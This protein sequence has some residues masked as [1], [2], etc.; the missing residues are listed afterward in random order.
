MKCDWI[1]RD[2]LWL[3]F[4]MTEDNKVTGIEYLWKDLEKE[5]VASWTSSHAVS[6]GLSGDRM[7][8]KLKYRYEVWLN[9]LRLALTAIH[10][11]SCISWSNVCVLLCKLLWIV[12]C[13]FLYC[14]ILCTYVMWMTMMMMMMIKQ[15]V[16]EV[17]VNSTKNEQGYKAS[18]Q[19]WT[20]IL[21]WRVTWR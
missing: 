3:Q 9:F 7:D 4:M 12:S 21:Y 18:M 14:V 15:D 2:W 20:V 6:T 19:C 5:N 1:L 17:A 13:A 10:S 8:W 11:L 16:K